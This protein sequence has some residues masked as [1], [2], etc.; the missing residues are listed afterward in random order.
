M[1][2]KFLLLCFVIIAYALMSTVVVRASNKE[3]NQT[4]V[5][6]KKRKIDVRDYAGDI[7]RA[8]R[9]GILLTTKVGDK[10]NSMTIGWGTIGIEWERPVFVAYVRTSRFTYEMLKGN[11]EFT[12]NVPIGDFPKKVLGLFGSQ[13]GRDM[14]KIAQSGVTLVQPNV[15]SVPGIKEFPLTLECRV[16]YSQEQEDYTLEEDIL[17]RFYRSD[18]SNHVAFYGEIVDAY[19]IEE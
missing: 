18:T 19:V 5:S 16:L 13:S 11:G 17:Q 7:I 6:M 4:F 15:I 3:N 12:I 1:Q 9:P 14:D 2:S 8:L 10:V